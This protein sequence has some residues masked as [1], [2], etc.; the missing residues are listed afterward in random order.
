MGMAFMG[1]AFMG[2]AFMGVVLTS[3]ALKY[4]QNFLWPFEEYMQH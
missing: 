2:V 3:L 4:P 1:V